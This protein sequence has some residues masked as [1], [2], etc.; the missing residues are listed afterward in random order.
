AKAIIAAADEV[1]AGKHPDE[2]P[3]VIWQTGSGTQTNMNM[4]EVLANRA[5]E[6]MNGPRGAGRLVHPNDDVHR[7]QS[8]NDVVPT[9][10][11]V[12]AVEAFS[13]NLLPAVRS[14]RDCLQ[15]KADHFADV[16]KLGRTHL[17]DAT[18][19]TL[20]QEISGWVALLDKG[21][22]HIEQS[23]GGLY[24]LALGGT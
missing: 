21:L 20:G 4:N 17:M 5:S 13:S 16:V 14:L 9:T 6:L 8:S 23:L 24:E 1:I 2:F 11:H 19:L 10:I 22:L 15:Q 12:A 7:G 3:L 18:P